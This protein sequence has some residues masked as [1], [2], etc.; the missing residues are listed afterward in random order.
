MGFFF[1]LVCHFCVHQNYVDN[2]L[3]TVSKDLVQNAAV[4]SKT[5]TQ[6]SATCNIVMPC[7]KKKKKVRLLVHLSV[8]FIPSGFPFLFFFNPLSRRC[9]KLLKGVL[10]KRNSPLPQTMR[11][12]KP[13]LQQHS[14]VPPSACENLD[15]NRNYPPSIHPPAHPPTGVTEEVDFDCVTDS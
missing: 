7:K 15:F 3:C 10:A 11:V 6:S 2:S 13:K 14:S 9:T 12:A 1:L 4:S 8:L 5:A